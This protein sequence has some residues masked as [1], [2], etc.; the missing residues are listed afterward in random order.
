MAYKKNVVYA[1]QRLSEEFDGMDMTVVYEGIYQGQ[2]LFST[3]QNPNPEG[4]IPRTG[5]PLFVLVDQHDFDRRKYVPDFYH[6]IA[7]AIDRKN[8]RKKKKAAKA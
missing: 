7:R 1:L 6:K 2:L 3:H 4:L 5:Y 8:E